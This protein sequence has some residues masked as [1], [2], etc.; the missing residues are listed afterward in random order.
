METLGKRAAQ[1]LK[2]KV[3]QVETFREDWYK[4]EAKELALKEELS[5]IQGE[6]GRMYINFDN[7]KLR[8]EFNCLID[9]IHSELDMEVLREVITEEEKDY[10]MEQIS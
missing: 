4:N 6:N 3:D 8:F 7:D 9:A 1:I 10:I 2:D 5:L